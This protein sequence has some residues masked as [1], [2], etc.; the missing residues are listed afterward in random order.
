MLVRIVAGIVVGLRRD[1]ES[2]LKQVVTAMLDLHSR[3]G[4]YL[5]GREFQLVESMVVECLED[6]QPLLR[7]YL[8]R[9]HPLIRDACQ[10]SARPPPGEP[11]PSDA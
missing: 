2:L 6:P 1:G 10:A 5:S 7:R 4:T 9:H 11:E 3:R 8:G